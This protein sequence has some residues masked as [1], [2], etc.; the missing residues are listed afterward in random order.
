MSNP[1]FTSTFYRRDLGEASRFEEELANTIDDPAVARRVAQQAGLVPAV[2]DTSGPPSTFWSRILDKAS[3]AGL[4]EKLVKRIEEKWGDNNQIATAIANLRNATVS[5]SLQVTKLLLE[6]DRPFLGRKGLREA[7]PKVENWQSSVSIL[8]VR[9]APDTGRTH[10]QELIA[11]RN[12][13]D[14]RVLL[15]EN[16][17]LVSTMK[18]IW[19][20]AGATGPVPAVIAGEPLSTESAV[21]ADFWTDVFAVLDERDRRMWVLFDDLDKGPGRVE[22]RALAEVLAIQLVDVSFQRRLRLVL[23]GYPEA[24]LAA[25]NVPAAFVVDDVTEDLG[26]TEIKAFIDYCLRRAGR[27]AFDDPTLTSN[28]EK[29]CADARA[30]VTPTLSFA[31]AL[32]HV[33]RGWYV[34]TIKGAP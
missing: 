28:S 11:D 25:K 24:Q 13:K 14:V 6:G 15:N 19:S 29:L 34:S 32:N 7:L 23:L 33:V 27:K 22:V 5:G 26:T 17:Q 18:R 1:I 2:I 12:G 4:L 3:Q 16:L 31:E 30:L 21:L 10:T 20:V 8:V 9:G